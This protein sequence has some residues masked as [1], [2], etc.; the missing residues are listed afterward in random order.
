MFILKRPNTARRQ[1]MTTINLLQKHFK[2]LWYYAVSNWYYIL[3]QLLSV[4]KSSIAE[5]QIERIFWISSMAFTGMLCMFT[6]KEH[7]P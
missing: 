1:Q 3:I 5:Q 4:T 2:Q 7:A 6:I